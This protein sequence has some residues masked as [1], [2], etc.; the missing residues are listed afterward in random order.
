MGVSFGGLLGG[1]LASILSTPPTLCVSTPFLV[2]RR[3]P[4]VS[5]LFGLFWNH[6]LVFLLEPCGPNDKKMCFVALCRL[7]ERSIWVSKRG[8]SCNAMCS[9]VLVCVLGCWA[10]FSSHER[11]FF[12][13]WAACHIPAVQPQTASMSKFPRL[14][15]R[16]ARG[17]IR[18]QSIRIQAIEWYLS[19]ADEDNALGCRVV[20]GWCEL[21]LQRV[22]RGMCCTK[23][24][25]R[26]HCEFPHFY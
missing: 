25:L 11:F 3:R 8:C 2:L 15:G 1:H 14:G 22:F 9:C 10:P 12:Q 5:A 19:C 4:H 18:S 23:A 13:C 17:S 7:Q 21:C 20:R 6:R 16:L 24:P 26:K